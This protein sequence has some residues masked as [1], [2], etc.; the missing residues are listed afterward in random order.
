MMRI[1][2]AGACKAF[3]WTFVYPHVMH[4][5]TESIMHRPTHPL[6]SLLEQKFKEADKT[7]L[8]TYVYSAARVSKKAFIRQHHGRRIRHA[9]MDAL[10]DIGLDK[11]GWPLIETGLTLG[12]QA[13]P[14]MGCL[15][16]LPR[17]PVLTAEYQDLVVAGREMLSKIRQ[18]SSKPQQNSRPQRSVQR[19]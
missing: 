18:A 4:K 11:E 17:E 12:S 8:W 19:R 3:D 2:T 9:I 10:K 16:I 6:R 15:S 7:L 1:K 13:S 14:I 5:T